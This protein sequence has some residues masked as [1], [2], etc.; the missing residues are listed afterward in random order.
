[1]VPFRLRLKPI[2]ILLVGFRAETKPS[3]QAS[4]LH[5]CWRCNSR[6]SEEL[7]LREALEMLAMEVYA[8]IRQFVLASGPITVARMAG[9]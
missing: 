7:L 5:R 9:V 3:T 1:M 4:A 8:A 2:E 6:L